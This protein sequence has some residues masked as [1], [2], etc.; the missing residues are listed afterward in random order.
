MA[1]GEHKILLTYSYWSDGVFVQIVFWIQ[2]IGICIARQFIS[3][4]ECV[5]DG[6]V[7]VRF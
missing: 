2:Q 5:F 3:K 6:L 7:H 1:S 4:L